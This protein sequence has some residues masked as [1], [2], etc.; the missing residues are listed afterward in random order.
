MGEATVPAEQPASGEASRVPAPD[1]DSGRPGHHQGAPGQGPRPPVGLSAG[2]PTRRGVVWRVRDRNTFV[3]LRHGRRARCGLLTVSWA[4][5][6]E[7]P[8]RLAFAIGRKVGSAVHRNRL[9]RRLR[10]LAG[11]TGLPPGAW[12]VSA[13][14]GAAEA[15]FD[16]LSGW[17]RGAVARLVSEDPVA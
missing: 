16:V 10:A 12:L 5:A 7:G 11:R 9:R 2:T 8:P 13:S 1:V 17:W 14:P 3:A 15:S 4:P 6:G